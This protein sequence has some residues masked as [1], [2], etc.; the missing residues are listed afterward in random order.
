MFKEKLV[1]V[2]F[3]AIIL[4][5]IAWMAFIPIWQTPDEQA[6]F[7]QVSVMAELNSL[8][9]PKLNLSR[10][11][12]ESEKELG[13]LRDDFGNNKFTYHPEYNI[14]YSKSLDGPKE[15]KLKSMPSESRTEF[16]KNEAAWYP[17]LYYAAGAVF[18]K[19]FNLGSIF[20]RVFAVR[21]LNIFLLFGLC[22]IT[23]KIGKLVFSEKMMAVFLTVLVSFAPM[24][25]FVFAGVTSD[26]LFI[27]LFSLFLWRC[28]LLL[29]DGLKFRN[30]LIIA[31]IMFLGFLTKPQANIMSFTLIPLLIFLLLTK[32]KNLKSW[33]FASVLVLLSLGGILLRL[34]R[35]GSLIPEAS[36][37]LSYSAAEIAE[38]LDFTIK[39][40]YRE[41]LPWFWGVFRWLS[42]GL[43]ENLRKLTNWLT[44]LSIFGFFFQLAREFKQNHHAEKF[45]MK[46]FLALS[47]AVYFLALTAFDFAFRK[48]HG[49]SFGI[50]GRYFFPVIIPFSLIFL[51]GLLAFF[52]KKW[53]TKVGLILSISMIIF[54]IFV[55]FL[56]TMSYYNPHPLAF[57]W[58]ASQYK[59]VWLKFPINAVILLGFFISTALAIFEQ[60][61]KVYAKKT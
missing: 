1:K 30:L 61:K 40:T 7:A 21:I 38:H 19:L 24:V 46:V 47:M 35:G 16:V 13:V 49:Y 58:E 37:N 5:Q 53:E 33:I 55:F 10:E 12:Y 4:K 9:L 31:L 11:I 26:P 6:H 17:P 27:F 22:L 44:L 41:V 18:Y 36:S 45:Q 25:T 28:L 56:V 42:Q 8:H 23:F 20:D 2:V 48:A 51:Q 3:L 50:Q 59:P 29:K 32:N 34:V 15:N 14:P 60:T 52:P 39:H 54:N 57:L 43:P